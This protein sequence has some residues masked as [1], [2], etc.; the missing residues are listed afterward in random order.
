MLPWQA[1]ERGLWLAAQH[2][3]LWTVLQS[4]WPAPRWGPGPAHYLLLAALHSL[5]APGA[6]TEVADWT[7]RRNKSWRVTPA[8]RRWKEFSGV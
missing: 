1:D 3:G 4:L 5:C 6:K 7:G 2:S 8:S